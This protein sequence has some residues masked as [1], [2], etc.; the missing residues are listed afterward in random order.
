VSETECWLSIIGIGE[1]RRE[2]L[3]LQSLAA[4]A[5]ADHVFG[6]PRH[7]ALADLDEDP[8]YRSGRCPS[9]SIRCWPCAGQVAVLASGDPFWFGAGQ[10]LP[11]I[12]AQANGAPFPRPRPFRWPPRGWAGGSRNRMPWPARRAVRATG[13]GHGPRRAGNLPLARRGGGR[14]PCRLADGASSGTVRAMCSKLLAARMSAYAPGART[15]RPLT[16]CGRRS[17]WP[18]PLP[19]TPGFRVQAAFPIRSLPMTDRSPSAR[20]GR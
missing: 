3:P 20:S 14:R 9:R 2:A 15:R 7:L 19:E 18:W 11:S 10:A 12:S 16:T 17:P 8:A 5:H 4:L 1:D 13:P 6:A